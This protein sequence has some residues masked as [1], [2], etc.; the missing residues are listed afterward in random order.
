M[1]YPAECW[2]GTGGLVS[3]EPRDSAINY[4]GRKVIRQQTSHCK[5][6]G[7]EIFPTF[8]KYMQ[9]HTDT[10]PFTYWRTQARLEKC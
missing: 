2:L 10:A 7:P 8:F 4:R 9:K 3:N 6:K 1:I 5:R